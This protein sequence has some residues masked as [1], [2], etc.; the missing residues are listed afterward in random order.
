[1]M[2]AAVTMM[3][4]MLGRPLGLVMMM[5]VVLVGRR[6][7]AIIPNNIIIIIGRMLLKNI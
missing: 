4:A 6:T 3:M 1:M 2:T 7:A 5:V